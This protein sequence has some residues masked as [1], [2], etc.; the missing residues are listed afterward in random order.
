[1]ELKSC[2]KII[3]S[4]SSEENMNGIVNFIKQLSIMS[5]LSSPILNVVFKHIIKSERR[6]MFKCTPFLTEKEILVPE[7]TDR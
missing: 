5:E 1:M 2:N 3:V 6:H 4:P 7:I